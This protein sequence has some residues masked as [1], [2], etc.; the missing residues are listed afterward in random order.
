[1]STSTLSTGKQALQAETTIPHLPG[2]RSHGAGSG[3]STNGS[4]EAFGARDLGTTNMTREPQPRPK[5]VPGAGFPAPEAVLGEN[6]SG[7]PT[8]G[9]CRRTNGRNL[10]TQ[11]PSIGSDRDTDGQSQPVRGPNLRSERVPGVIGPVRASEAILGRCECIEP[12][13]ERGVSNARV[14]SMAE[15]AVLSP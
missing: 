10:W 8:A 2:R 14:E 4:T 3:S 15:G 7:Y 1:M 5:R 13:S 11:V 6:G 9:D 12:R